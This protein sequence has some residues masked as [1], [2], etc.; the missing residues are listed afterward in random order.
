MYTPG[1][2]RFSNC[3]ARS[4]NCISIANKIMGMITINF[5]LFFFCCLLLKRSWGMA[6]GERQTNSCD[7]FHINIGLK[8]KA[9]RQHHIR[10]QR[11][12]SY[13]HTA[14]GEERGVNHFRKEGTVK[15]DLSVGFSKPFMEFFF[16]PS[17]NEEHTRH[18]VTMFES[19]RKPLIC[20]EFKCKWAEI[21]TGVKH[22]PTDSRPFHPLTYDSECEPFKDV[23]IQGRY[24]TVSKHAA[25]ISSINFE[26]GMRCLKCR[27]RSG[28]QLTAIFYLLIKHTPKANLIFN[29]ARKL[30]LP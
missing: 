15:K 5:F 18:T 27:L 28:M 16:F 9:H 25:K 3:Q 6:F 23:H 29:R 30:V 13:D 11:Q 26:Q 19:N 24:D 10:I 12:D 17:L 7:P 14:R 4:N 21:V 1:A 8:V 22:S 2:A 20:I